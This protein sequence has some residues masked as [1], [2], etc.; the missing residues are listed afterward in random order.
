MVVLIFQ[1]SNIT[2]NQ[3]FFSG[4]IELFYKLPIQRNSNRYPSRPSVHPSIRL[5]SILN[6]VLFTLVE[7]K[8]N[9]TFI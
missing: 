3:I 7:L 5:S 1:Y 4:E 2:R 8:I 6:N 9:T